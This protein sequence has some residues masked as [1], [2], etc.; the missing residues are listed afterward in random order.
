MKADLERRLVALEAKK[1]PLSAWC[2]FVMPMGVDDEAIIGYEHNGGV[3]M[4][5]PCET[6]ESLK[7]RTLEA[8]GPSTVVLIKPV[9]ADRDQIARREVC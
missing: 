3:V 6:L 4:R 7:A 8:I 5:E 1:A 2:V 9:V